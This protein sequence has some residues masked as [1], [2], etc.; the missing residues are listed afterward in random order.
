MAKNA[1]ILFRVNIGRAALRTLDVRAPPGT[2][3]TLV[4]S[5]DEKVYCFD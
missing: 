4:T 1:E 3:D 2:L 5:N